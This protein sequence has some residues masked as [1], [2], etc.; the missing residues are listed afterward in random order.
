MVMK[1]LFNNL[2]STFLVARRKS[3]WTKLKCWSC[4]AARWYTW[5]RI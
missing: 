5:N 3:Q 1:D 4:V 2:Y